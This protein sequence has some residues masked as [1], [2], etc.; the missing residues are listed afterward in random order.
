MP[1]MVRCKVPRG[2]LGN[3]LLPGQKTKGDTVSP[4]RVMVIL[5][6]MMVFMMVMHSDVLLCPQSLLLML[7]FHL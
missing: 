4:L 3:D 6:M 2:T 1:T 7:F 5:L